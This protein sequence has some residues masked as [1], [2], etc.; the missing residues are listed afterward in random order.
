MAVGHREAERKL[1]VTEPNWKELGDPMHDRLP[2]DR[3]VEPT[4]PHVMLKTDRTIVVETIQ[5]L[6]PVCQGCGT[7]EGN[8]YTRMNTGS[9]T[10]R[11]KCR[12]CEGTGTIPGTRTTTVGVEHRVR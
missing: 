11:E 4:A 7:V 12:R 1:A 3:K 2:P 9:L 8:F 6:C 10:G 5:T